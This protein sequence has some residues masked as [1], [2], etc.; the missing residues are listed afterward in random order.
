VSLRYLWLNKKGTRGLFAF[1][2]STCAMPYALC[3]LTSI[4]RRT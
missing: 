4:P 2:P 3:R 1:A